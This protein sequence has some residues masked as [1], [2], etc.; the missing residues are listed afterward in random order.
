MVILREDDRNKIDKVFFNLND[1]IIRRRAI[2]S[3]LRKLIRKGEH[4]VRIPDIG[5]IRI[6]NGRLVEPHNRVGF[7]TEYLNIGNYNGDIIELTYFLK[8]LGGM[9]TNI[10]KA[11]LDLKLVNNNEIIDVFIKTGDLDKTITAVS[12]NISLV[13]EKISKLRR[14]VLGR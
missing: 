6:Q 11:L 12:Q 9:T 13:N 3:E 7:L 1:I 10:K 2:I 5:H 14:I 4:I 8:G